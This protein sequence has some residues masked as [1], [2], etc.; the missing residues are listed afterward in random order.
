MALWRSSVRTRYAP[1]KIKK[2]SRKRG[3]FYFDSKLI[4]ALGAILRLSVW[5]QSVKPFEEL[6]WIVTDWAPLV[7]TLKKIVEGRPFALVASPTS[8]SPEFVACQPQTPNG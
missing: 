6:Q 8:N 4:C 5:S 3:L 2:A 7:L 1:P